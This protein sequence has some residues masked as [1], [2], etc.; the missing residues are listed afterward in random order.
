[1]YQIAVLVKESQ[2]H[3]NLRTKATVERGRESPCGFR[4]FRN[5]GTH[6]GRNEASVLL[7]TS[8]VKMLEAVDHSADMLAF[9]R[10]SLVGYRGQRVQLHYRLAVENGVWRE[11]L[12]CIDGFPAE[13]QLR[14]ADRPIMSNLRTLHYELERARC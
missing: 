5:V 10:R 3:K 12:H 6:S 8:F 9:R 7:S 1:M 14:C 11:N 13:H 2:S 4:D